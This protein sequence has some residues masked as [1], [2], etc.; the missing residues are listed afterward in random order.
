[1]V[2][3]ETLMDEMGIQISAAEGKIGEKAREFAEM[4]ISSYNAGHED[5]LGK[6]EQDVREYLV[7]EFKKMLEKH[8]FCEEVAELTSH[9]K[10]K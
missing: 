4:L 3:T 10:L 2:Y 1:M 6:F 7:R 8:R 9:S 5:G